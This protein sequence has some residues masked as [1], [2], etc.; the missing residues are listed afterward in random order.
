MVHIRQRY[1][2]LVLLACLLGGC[3]DQKT[4]IQTSIPKDE[5]AC[6]RRFI[7]AVRIGDYLTVQQIGDFSRVNSEQATRRLRALHE[8]LGR[9]KPTSVETVGFHN[10]YFQSGA[11]AGHDTALLYQIRFPSGWVAGEVIL[12]K[13][14]DSIRVIGSH[15]DVVS[16]SLEV[17]NRFS[18]KG[19]TP[20]Q[21]A[22]LSACIAI[23]VYIL[24]TLVLCIRSQV[25]YKWAWLLFILFGIA[26]V[27]VDWTSGR[28]GLEPFS[29][30]LFGA[31]AFRPGFGSL[32]WILSCGFPLGATMFLNRFHNVVGVFKIALTVTAVVL[33]V[34][35]LNAS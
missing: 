3:L 31:S 8:L 19:K 12:T 7:E 28:M 11:A 14:P 34:M 9:E 22:F 21:Y 5:D 13:K 20:K 15:F 33:L 30:M 6:A 27:H 29:V 2:L 25:S 4:L 24:L 17:L 23:P 35:F 10:T 32:P 18:I 1:I 26:Q 16:N